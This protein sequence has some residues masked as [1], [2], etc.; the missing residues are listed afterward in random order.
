MSFERIDVQT[1]KQRLDEGWEPFV[2][3]V[4][5]AS[6]ADLVSFDF[7]DHLHPHSSITEIAADLPKDR[8]IVIHCRSGARSAMACMQLAGLGFGQLYNL[9]GGILA[10]AREIDPS[11]PTY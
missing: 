1:F 3:D 7:V 11:M 9:E 5:G 2:L 6:E 8:E 4:R 10:W